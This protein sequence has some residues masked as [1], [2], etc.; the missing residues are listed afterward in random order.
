MLVKSIGIHV[1]RRTNADRPANAGKLRNLTMADLRSV[2]DGG[3]AEH[4][5]NELIA[6]LADG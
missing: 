6:I 1:E 3:D 4:A 2:V 5:A